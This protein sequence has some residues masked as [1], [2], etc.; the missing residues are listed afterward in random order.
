MTLKQWQDNGWLRPHATSPE[1]IGN[2]LA[3]VGRDLE[4]AR[5]GLTPALGVPPQVIYQAAPRGR[6]AHV[7]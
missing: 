5:G 6:E 1:E 3:I 2:L 4:D 7:A